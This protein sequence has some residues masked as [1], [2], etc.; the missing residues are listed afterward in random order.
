MS[1]VTDASPVSGAA[2]SRAE[3]AVESK[4]DSAVGAASWSGVSCTLV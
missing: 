3:E 4:V 1:M 2:K